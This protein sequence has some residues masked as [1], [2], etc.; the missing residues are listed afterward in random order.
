VC[1][2]LSLWQPHMHWS[3]TEPRSG[4]R[5]FRQGNLKVQRSKLKT[6]DYPVHD[7]PC[8][9]SMYDEEEKAQMGTSRTTTTSSSSS[10]RNRWWR[11]TRN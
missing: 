9:G 7:T 2:S 4:A 6:E 1:V 3:T 11:I 10:S 8:M 5:S